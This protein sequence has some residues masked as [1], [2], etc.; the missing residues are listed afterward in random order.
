[1]LELKKWLYREIFLC[2]NVLRLFL[3]YEFCK[4]W[5]ILFLLRFFDDIG[6]FF[7]VKY[8]NLSVFKLN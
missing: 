1:M 8:K 4:C 2:K 3:G 7:F 6:I 5:D